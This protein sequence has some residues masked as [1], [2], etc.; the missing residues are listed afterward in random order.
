MKKVL[1]IGYP[2]P[3]K[4][5]GSPRVL[6]LA[7]YLPEFG[8]SP[9]IL[10]PPLDTE[11]DPAYRIIETGYRDILAFWRKLF[12]FNA[13]DD[14]RKQVKGRFGVTG[15]KTILDRLMTF[16]G[17]IINYPDSEKGWKRFAVDAGDEFLR[18]EK[19]DAI[20]SSSAPVIGH[21]I[22][23][24]LATRYDIP[25]VADL[26]DP[27]TQNHNYS[28]SRIRRAI[29]RRLEVKTL[30]DA[31]AL[32]I[33]SRPWADN[34]NTLHRHTK[35]YVITNGF[36]PETV[37]TPPA[38]LTE[39]FT[40][41]Y[42]GL[43]YPD[44]QDVGR[45]FEAVR[46]LIAE[47]A[48]DAGRIEIRFYGPVETWMEK[49]V[50][51]RGLSGAVTQYGPASRDIAIRK[52]RESQVLLLLNWDDPREKGT[53][54]GKIFEYLAARRPILSTGGSEDDVVTGLLRETQAGVNT[55]T[56]ESTV[57]AIREM[58]AEYAASGGVTCHGDERAIAAYNQREMAKKYAEVL[59]SLG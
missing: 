34:L 14:I 50:E 35:A 38:A 20:I 37:N 11:P 18:G 22:A 40:I 55:I 4:Q 53:Y 43:I 39:K 36:D 47:K 16:T 21:V 44:R 7:K 8:W 26:R 51:R 23:R 24:E 6:G 33:V 52:Q 46:M 3:L 29:D 59:N 41:T 13:E 54:P 48:L 31:A 2:F 32:V 30:A 58:Y 28:Y 15:K 1:I 12:R 27:W 5:G 56:I 42:T 10:T 57:E 9:T 17:E 19:M 45:L 25:W 49:E